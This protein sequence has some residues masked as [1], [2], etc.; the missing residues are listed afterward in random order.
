MTRTLAAVVIA[1]VAALIPAAAH[2]TSEGRSVDRWDTVYTLAED[3]SARVRVEI[4]FDFGNNPGHGPYWTLPIKQGYDDT[5]DRMYQVT[6]VTASSPTGAPASVYLE[7]GDAWL[8]VRVGDTAVDNVSGVQTYVLEYTV[9]GVMNSTTAEETSTGAAGDEFYW[10][11]IGD[12]WE[13]P[14]R[15]ASVTVVGLADVTDAR[16][17]AGATGATSACGQAEISGATATFAQDSLA[18]G[19]P[20]SV[21]VL[22]PAGTYATQPVLVESND[23][24]RAFRITPWTVGGALLILFGGG[25]LIVRRLLASGTDQ[26]YAGI[27][28]GNSPALGAEASVTRRDRSA[29]VAVAFAPPAGLRPGQL[30][31]LIDEKADPRDVTATV[32]DLAVRGYLVIE[33]VQAVGDGRGPGKKG[34]APEDYVLIKSRDVD[35]ALL[36]YERHL[37]EAIFDARDRIPLS[38][39]TITLHPDAES[40]QAELYREVTALGWFKGNPSHVRNTWAGGGLALIVGGVMGIIALAAWTSAALLGVP[41]VIL[42]VVMLATAKAAPAR[43]PEGSRI[44]AQARGFELYLRTAEGEQLRFEEGQD[45]FSRYLPY[46]IAFGVA[47]QWARAFEKLAAQGAALAEPTWYHGV[48]YGAFWLHAGGF[49]HRMSE[50]AQL[51]DAAMSPATP[52]SSGGSAFSGGGFSGGGFSGGGGGGGGGGGW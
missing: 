37:F 27:T 36:A 6:D 40:V 38:E 25:W 48:A 10:N 14:V 20:F 4:D 13:T 9:A 17:W 1:L 19:E 45:I 42:G 12:G 28:P 43:T 49:G 31:T 21:A 24:A 33:E 34:K 22:Y 41:V 50:F 46:A 8:V 51:A 2:A 23:F 18:P 11:A 39:L 30:G 26:A 3:G 15:N 35:E 47:E 52:S 7:E 44:L 5:H 32:V 16:C 29:P